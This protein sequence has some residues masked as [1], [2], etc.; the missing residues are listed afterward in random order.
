MWRTFQLSH[1]FVKILLFADSSALLIVV[2]TL[3]HIR[4]KNKIHLFT[5]K[6]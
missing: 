1:V 4:Y 5:V 6:I 2:I 3:M